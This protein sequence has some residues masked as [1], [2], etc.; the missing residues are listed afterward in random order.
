[1]KTGKYGP[2]KMPYLDNFHAV[3]NLSVKAFHDI[4]IFEVDGIVS[5]KKKPVSK[6]RDFSNG[7]F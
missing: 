7:F 1:M 2:E 6:T 3:S 5:N 4:I